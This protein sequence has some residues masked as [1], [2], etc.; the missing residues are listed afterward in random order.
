MLKINDILWV[1]FSG[2]FLAT[3]YIIIKSMAGNFLR[4]K[5]HHLILAFLIGFLLCPPAYADPGSDNSTILHTEFPE[6]EIS[7]FINDIV[8]RDVTVQPNSAGIL[9]DETVQLQARV[10]VDDPDEAEEEDLEVR[11]SSS[12]EFVASV[13]EDGTVTGISQGEAVITAT[14]VADPDVSGSAH[15]TVRGVGRTGV[16]RPGEFTEFEGGLLIGTHPDAIEEPV[17]VEIEW[18]MPPHEDTGEP[19]N[20]RFVKINITEFPFD[21]GWLAAPAGTGFIVGIP[22]PDEFDVSVLG[23]FQHVYGDFTYDGDP[24]D[25]WL[26]RSGVYDPQHRLFIFH[27]AAVG[28]QDYPTQLGIVEHEDPQPLLEEELIDRV[29]DEVFDEATHRNSRMNQDISTPNI[30]TS[31]HDIGFNIF[32]H[33]DGPCDS[34]VVDSVK[35]ALAGDAETISHDLEDYIVLTE[36]IDPN[37][38]LAVVKYKTLNGNPQPLLTYATEGW[39]NPTTFY[40]YTIYSDE[41]KLP[42]VFRAFLDSNPCPELNSGRQLAGMHTPVGHAWTCENAPEPAET[43]RHELFHAIQGSYYV[44]EPGF[45]DDMFDDVLKVNELA[46]DFLNEEYQE[47]LFEG[48][49]RL[50]Q[51]H[52]QPLSLSGKEDLMLVNRSPYDQRPYR[53]EH[54]FHYIF[55]W[56]GI[57]F[58]KMGDLFETGFRWEDIKGFF[59][60]PPQALD[61]ERLHWDWIRNAVFEGKVEPDSLYGD[62]CGINDDAFESVGSSSDFKMLDL[63]EESSQTL[64]I[65]E[66]SANILRIALPDIDYKHYYEVSIDDDSDRV[67]VYTDDTEFDELNDRC[68]EL[69]GSELKFEPGVDNDHFPDNGYVG[70]IERFPQVKAER[71]A[72]VLVFNSAKG[73]E[74]SY[75]I[76]VDGPHPLFDLT[77][78]ADEGG[79]VTEPGQGEFTY[80]EDEEVELLAEPDDEYQFDLWTG[81]IGNVNDPGSASAIVTM[82]DNYEITA[83]FAPERNLE[84]TICGAGTVELDPEDVEGHYLAERPEGL[85]IYAEGDTVQLEAVPNDIPDQ[86]WDPSFL[87]AIPEE[88][89]DSLEIPPPEE[90]PVFIRWEAKNPGTFFEDEAENPG[91]DSYTDSLLV[92]PMLDERMGEDDETREIHAVFT[93]G[94]SPCLGSPE[95]EPPTLDDFDFHQPVL[96]DYDT[97]I[98]IGIADPIGPGYFYNLV[99]REVRDEN[100][101]GRLVYSD[102]FGNASFS[103]STRELH[104]GRIYYFQV[105]AIHETGLVSEFT[106]PLYFE[107]SDSQELHVDFTFEDP[108]DRDNY[109]LVGLP[110]QLDIDLR[111]TVSG[112]PGTDWRAFHEGGSDELYEY[113]GSEDFRFQP[114]RGFWLLAQDGWSFEGTVTALETI[115]DEVPI[116]VQQGWNIVSNPLAQDIAWSDIQARNELDT[117]LW[118]WDGSWQEA[119]TFVSALDGGAY[120]IYIENDDRENLILSQMEDDRDKSLADSRALTNDETVLSLEAFVHDERAA[121][122]TVGISDNEDKIKYH[123]SPPAHFEEVSL[124][125]INNDTETEDSDYEYSRL[126]VPN[127]G[128]EGQTFNLILRG[129]PGDVVKLRASD[130]GE[131]RDQKI[132]LESPSGNRLDDLH[133]TPE[134]TVPI[135]ADDGEKLLLLHIGSEE[136]IRDKETPEELI[137]KSPYPNPTNT[138]ATIEYMLPEEMNIRVATYNILGREVAVLE[139]GIQSA[140]SHVTKWNAAGVATGTYFIRLEAGGKAEIQKLVII[141]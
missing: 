141:K 63:N 71:Y 76:D 131:L 72:Y 8:V 34:E 95:Y 114:G 124:N 117:P 21:E 26:K 140:G 129:D 133:K 70:R 2:Q 4:G 122:V 75:Q 120:Y 104:P 49:A 85:F 5:W 105:R 37:E 9:V 53:G 87:E 113:D 134:I 62:R 83:T 112:N 24:D 41:E 23:S 107:L 103:Y 92:L 35:Y 50:A 40:D 14:S 1:S 56:G 121:G 65:D 51:D 106:E 10:V 93:G 45:L 110:G 59:E 118:Q 19:R 116:D 58:E 48:T 32:Q 47:F 86:G 79:S 28:M 55:H 60:S 98:D 67:W 132:Y 119:R 123:R 78:S 139:E 135:S 94:A 74:K 84:I 102:V 18:F 22:V 128:G 17:T 101:E 7:N 127:E 115:E 11:W 46:L 13:D 54:L 38:D 25:F 109:R 68:T 33:C 80:P 27:L 96:R 100:D 43:T 130:I 36:E 125:I 57:E 31:G 81:D 66:L 3:Y 30:H 16:L 99:V 69:P 6:Y 73:G 52:T 137:L 111:E 88:M 20:D 136:Y 61:F 89:R 42:L 138:S 97:R 12:D 44:P 91:D 90:H 15:I 77:L 64:T 82:E 29:R 108:T 39:F 126:V